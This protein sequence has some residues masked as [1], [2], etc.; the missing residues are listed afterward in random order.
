LFIVLEHTVLNHENTMKVNLEDN[1][2]T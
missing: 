2:K 1:T